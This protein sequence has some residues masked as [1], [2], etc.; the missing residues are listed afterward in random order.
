MITQINTKIGEIMLK[1][2]P[3][4]KYTGHQKSDSNWEILNGQPKIEF[5]YSDVHLALDK[6]VSSDE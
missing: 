5:F 1:I 6:V 3:C 2:I 4:L